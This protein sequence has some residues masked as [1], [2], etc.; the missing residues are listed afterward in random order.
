MYN[1]AYL[2]IQRIG[3]AEAGWVVTENPTIPLEFQEAYATELVQRVTVEGGVLKIPDEFLDIVLVN[4]KFDEK[5]NEGLVKPAFHKLL[6][7]V[8]VGTLKPIGQGLLGLVSEAHKVLSELILQS[9]FEPDPN[10][11]ETPAGLSD[12]TEEVDGL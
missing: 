1:I 2:W 5:S 11:N 10:I 7:S 4:F 8:L 9:T 3:R 12:N 6:K